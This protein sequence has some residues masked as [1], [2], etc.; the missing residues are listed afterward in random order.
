MVNGNIQVFSLK[1]GLKISVSNQ[2]PTC[3]GI[4]LKTHL[5]DFLLHKRKDDCTYGHLNF[6]T[7][8]MLKMG[9]FIYYKLH[10]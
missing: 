4:D 3:I 1:L 2:I 5:D 9:I 7:K 10:L 8:L 6:A